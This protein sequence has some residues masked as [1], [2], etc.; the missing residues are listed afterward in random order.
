MQLNCRQAISSVANDNCCWLPK[1]PRLCVPFESC[2]PFHTCAAAERTF[3]IRLLDRFFRLALQV[4]ART[5]DKLT[6]Y[7][8]LV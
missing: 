3:N 2:S 5:R 6:A 4:L 1:I 8:S 7:R